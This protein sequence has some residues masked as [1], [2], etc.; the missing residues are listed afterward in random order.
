MASGLVNRK[1][2]ESDVQV[3]I[4]QGQEE[5]DAARVAN[6]LAKRKGSESDVQGQIGQGQKQEGKQGSGDNT[7]E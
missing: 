1:G 5:T 3:Q 4:G 6:G 2:S 7:S